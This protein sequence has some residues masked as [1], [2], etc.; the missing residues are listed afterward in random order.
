MIKLFSLGEIYVSDFL[1]PGELPRGPKHD[2]QL[3]LEKGTGAVRLETT[4]PLDTMFGKYWYRSG[5]NATMREA[6]YDIVK[7]INKVKKLN[8]ND[9]WIDVAANDGQLLSY[10]PKTLRRIGIDPAD[11]SFKNESQKHADYIIQDYFS[12]EVYKKSKLGYRQADVIT[13]I[14]MFYDLEDP[15]KFID[16]I[17]EVLDEN[18]LWVMQLS[19]TPLMLKQ[20]AFDNILS[21]HVYYYSLF[22][23][24]KLL[25]EGGFQVMDCQLND[26][27]GGSFRV[28]IMKSS[29]DKSTFATQPY[30]DVAEF[31]IKSLL[32]YEGTLGLDEPGTWFDFFDKI[33]E[34]RK[35]TREFIKQ[36]KGEG[37]TVFGYGSSTKGNTLL[38]YFNLDNTMIDGIADRS[39]YKHGLYTVGT[40][41]PICSEEEMRKAKPDYLLV[42]PWHFIDEF[43]KREHEFLDNGGKFIVPCPRFEIIGK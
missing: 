1:K 8:D 27:N 22:N 6:L 18:G 29:A 17:Y 25:K 2:L 35:K 3:C 5:I 14:A 39:E 30:R 28:Y 9:I 7:S 37:K 15:R 4:A 38:Q 40:N 21:E 20:M 12:A 33:N 11:D 36:A 16:D 13:S 10:V 26:I 31:R 34:L 23:L 32:E 41:I 19:Y 42:L 24:R 43:K